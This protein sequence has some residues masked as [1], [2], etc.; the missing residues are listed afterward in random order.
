V[1]AR[2]STSVSYPASAAVSPTAPIPRDPTNASASSGSRRKTAIAY[3]IRST[4]ARI[5]TS[6]NWTTA[7]RTPAA[8][9]RPDPSS[10]SARK[11]STAREER[12]AS[13]TTSVTWA[14]TTAIARRKTA[15]TSLDRSTAPARLDSSTDLMARNAAT[16]TSAR[17][18]CAGRCT[19]ARICPGRTDA[20]ARRDGCTTNELLLLQISTS[21]LAAR[22]TP[23]APVPPR[24]SVSTLRDH[25]L[26]T[27]LLDTRTT[28][29]RTPA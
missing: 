1:N 19:S 2:T 16:R 12:S 10:A 15:S 25:S 27:A 29:R 18:K 4:S 20:S 14:R 24:E 9:T 28:S 7:T 13:T 26:A 17:R 3:P 8:S 21:V 5:A 23:T 11:A 22:T 6:S